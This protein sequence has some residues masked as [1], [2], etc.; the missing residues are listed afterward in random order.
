MP[1]SLTDVGESLALLFL[2]GQTVTAPTGLRVRLASTAGS[3][4]AAGTGVTGAV[5]ACTFGAVTG[6][7]PSQVVNTT[8]LSYAS[9]PAVSGSGVV[10]FEV[11]DSTGRR[12]YAGTFDAA[13]IVNAGDTYTIPAGALVLTQD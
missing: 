2:T 6:T 5:Q 4:A 1:G 11:E 8:A 12:I 13:K 10:A 7:T 3:D 9:M